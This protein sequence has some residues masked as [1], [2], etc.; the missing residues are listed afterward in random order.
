VVAI[1]RDENW[2]SDSNVAAYLS[3]MIG[4]AALSGAAIHIRAA[5]R[6]GSEGHVRAA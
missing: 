1:L 4:A 5:Q 6:R 2:A 3:Q